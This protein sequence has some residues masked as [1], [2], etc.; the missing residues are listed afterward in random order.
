M[1]TIKFMRQ[2]YFR[3]KLSDRQTREAWEK[4]GALDSRERARQKT[5]EILQ[6]HSPKVID[7][8]IDQEIQKRFDI[9]KKQ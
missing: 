6:T 4:S 5:N 3:Q 8:K 7:P 9:V 2:E 1:H